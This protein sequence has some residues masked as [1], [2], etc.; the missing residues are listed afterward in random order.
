MSWTFK[1]ATEPFICTRIQLKSEPQLN[2][3][4]ASGKTASK[5]IELTLDFWNAMRVAITRGLSNFPDAYAA[6]TESMAKVYQDFG[7]SP[8]P[9]T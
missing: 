5:N 2:A 1:P 9:A 3:A 4:G 8:K 7:L 6:I